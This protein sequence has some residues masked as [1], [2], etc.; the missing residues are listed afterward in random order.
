MFVP[1]KSLCCT[2][3]AAFSSMSS[4]IRR[5]S[6]SSAAREKYKPSLRSAGSFSFRRYDI[7]RIRS[8]TGTSIWFSEF[9]FSFWNASISR[10]V[11]FSD[12][13]TF[14]SFFARKSRSF[15][16]VSVILLI[17]SMTSSSSCRRSRISRT[18]F[19]SFS[20]HPVG[21]T[22]SSSSSESSYSE[23]SSSSLLLSSSDSATS[24]FSSFF[25]ARRTRFVNTFCRY[26]RC[27]CSSGT[28]PPNSFT[29]FRLFSV[30]TASSSA[31]SS[32]RHSISKTLFSSSV[33]SASRSSILPRSV[34]SRFSN[35]FN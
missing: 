28:K 22:S 32:T 25:F 1:R 5:C 21:I 6:P 29:T 33:F 23:S 10:S 24:S 8:V 12:V 26:S 16:S 11:F 13:R 30:T 18:A 35:S 2:R 7:C 34:F 17:S 27:A 9:C 3:S 19:H 4:S 14:E 20:S 15:R 31:F